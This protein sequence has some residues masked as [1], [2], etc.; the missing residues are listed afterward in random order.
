MV[1]SLVTYFYPDL[2]SVEIKKFGLLSL[3]FFLIIGTY[4]LLRLL[5]ITIFLKVAFP[6][7]F[8]WD[9]QQGCLFQPLAKMWSPF[10]ILILVLVYSKLV[11]LVKKHQ[12][13]YI[14]SAFY[15]SLFIFF[16]AVLFVKDVYGVESIGKLALASMGWLSY[17]TIESFGSLVVGLFWSFSNSI[18]DSESAKRGF[19]FIVAMAQISAVLGSSTL[20]FSDSIGSLWP[21]MLFAAITVLAIIPLVRYFMKT[22]PE[23]EL[24]GNVAAAASEK[25]T[26]AF[27][28]GFSHDCTYCLLS[29]TYWVSLSYQLFMRQYL[30]LLNIR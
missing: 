5:K 22:I 27:L 20:L 11:D 24:V 17:F 21:I 14:F 19:P 2:K 3:I 6:V 9:A 26:K 7:C 1:S 8:G 23:Q 29:L 25:R 10:I 12:L 4:W 15:A 28:R 13:F 16:A 18:T 30:P